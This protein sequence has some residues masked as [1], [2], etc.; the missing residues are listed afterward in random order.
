MFLSIVLNLFWPQPAW[1]NCP[2]C[3]VT[4]GG[5]LFIAQRLG[6]DDLIITLWISGLNTAIAFFIADKI[7]KHGILK[8]GYFWAILFYLTT[9]FYFYSSSQAGIGNNLWGIDKVLLGLSLGLIIFFLS[10]SIDK[11]IRQKHHDKVLFYYQKVIIP[12]SFLFITSLIF[13]Q[14]L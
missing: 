7:K 13:N 12:L 3:I 5:G 10:I 2:V 4:V 1:A 9:V 11:F 6:I 14:L 8:N